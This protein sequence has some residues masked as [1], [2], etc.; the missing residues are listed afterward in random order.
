MGDTGA[1]IVGTITAVLIMRFNALNLTGILEHPVKN[2]PG[3][4][5]AI[6]F[7]P[8]YDTLRVFTLRIF[9]GNSPFS[10]DKNHIHHLL[11][12]LGCSHIQTSVILIS[13]NFIIIMIGYNFQSFSI[14]KLTIVL[15]LIGV[16][17]SNTL[18]HLI[19]QKELKQQK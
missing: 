8:L 5:I 10:A 18:K 12:R 7:I 15:L 9:S 11:L 4:S 2:V 13:V 1:L 16:L 17:F 6:I 3:M 14:G 19:H